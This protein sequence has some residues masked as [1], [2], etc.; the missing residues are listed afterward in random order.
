MNA[1]RTRRFLTYIVE[2]TLA[3]R[4]EGIKESLIGLEVFDRAADFDPKLDTVVRVEAGKLRK[5]LEEYYSGEGVRDALR[6]EVPKGGYVPVFKTCPEP[7]EEVKAGLVPVSHRRLYAALA[8]AGVAAAALVVWFAIRAD[9]PASKPDPSIAVLP[10]LNLSGNASD[11]YFADGLTEELT[12]ALCKTGGMR[13]VSRTSAFFFKGK[14]ADVQEIGKKL[15]VAYVVE[16]SVRKQGPRLKVTTQLIRADDG[17]HVWSGSF[18][19]ELKDVFEVQRQIAESAVRVLRA[20]VPLPQQARVRTTHS[21]NAHAFDLYLQGKH[22]LNNRSGADLK[23]AEKLFQE[24]ITADPAY[25]PTYVALT[26]VYSR[27]GI[28]SDTPASEL[29]AKSKAALE[30]AIALDDQLAEAHAFLGTISARHDHDLG[31]A[32]R[33]L[34][35]AVKLNPSCSQAHYQLAQNVLAPQE[36]WDEA[37]REN[38]LASELDPLSPLIAYSGPWLA[39]LKRDHATAVDGFGRLAVE[40]PTDRM[41]TGGLIAALMGRGDYA[42]AL[43]LLREQQ[44]RSPSYVSLAL[45]GHAEARSGNRAGAEKT[46]QEL[47]AAETTRRV[48]PICFAL[49]Y[50]GLGDADKS[51]R[52]LDRARLQDDFSYLIFA[53]VAHLYD[54]IR[55]DGKF[56]A[57]LASIGLADEQIQQNQRDNAGNHG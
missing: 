10:F 12:D 26:D 34:R 40:Y 15:H 35:Y 47:F 11:E 8:I 43:K 51:F 29:F 44:A 5:R 21:A 22:A 25:A 49:V 39:M 52:Y 54:P 23:L 2:E 36:R 19:R 18:E 1:A 14:Q 28:T 53:R 55:R 38:R 48:P 3:G 30:K 57:L 4:T 7:P 46:L 42:A 31:T 41:A 27:T 50:M 56:P 45:I 20:K 32:E 33:Q 13:V 24:S 9:K 16:G 37:M 17:Y 6:I